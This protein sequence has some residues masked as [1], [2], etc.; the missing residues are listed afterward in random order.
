[1]STEEDEKSMDVRAGDAPSPRFYRGKRVV[2]NGCF[3]ISASE[4]PLPL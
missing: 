2:K 4:D 1:M 3:A